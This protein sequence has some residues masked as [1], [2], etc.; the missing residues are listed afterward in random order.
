MT[1]GIAL[2]RAEIAALALKAA[3]GGGLD[4]GLAEEAAQATD[5]LCGQG[6]DGTAALLAALE[7]GG[8]APVPA[9]G[10]WR[11]AG[12]AMLCPLRS[13]AACSAPPTKAPRCASIT[14]CRGR[15]DASG[16]R[17]R[18]NPWTRRRTR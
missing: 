10:I 1:G 11:A 8:A 18:S 16:K 4:W 17:P 9:D 14:G 13:G 15:P 6:L 12:G 2:S 7:A 3:R 5:W